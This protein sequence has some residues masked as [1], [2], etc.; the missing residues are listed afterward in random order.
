MPAVLVLE[1]DPAVQATLCTMLILAG[2]TAHHAVTVDEALAIL[3]REHV[4]AVSLDVRVPDPKGLERSGLSVLT[5]LRTLPGYAAVPALIFTGMPL[6]PEEEE[7]AGKLNAPVFYKPQ[8]YSVLI[9]H[10][11]RQLHRRPEPAPRDN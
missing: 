9:Q 5:V 11:T 10:L 4:D 3:E 6:S 2:F 1:D 7:M 8:P